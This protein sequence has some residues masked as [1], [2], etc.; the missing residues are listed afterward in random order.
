M[1]K[2]ILLTKNDFGIICW[3]FIKSEDKPTNEQLLNYLD[4]LEENI[5]RLIDFPE[6]DD[7][8]DMIL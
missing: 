5:E 4:G 2:Y 8:F 3:Y 1:K 7:E 6:S